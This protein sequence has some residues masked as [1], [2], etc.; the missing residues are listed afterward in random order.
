M[1]ID[2]LTQRLRVCV[3]ANWMQFSVIYFAVT[4][5][6]N[7]FTNVRTKW[8]IGLFSS[9]FYSK[10]VVSKLFCKRSIGKYIWLCW[11][12]G[13]CCNYQTVAEWKKKKVKENVNKCVRL[14]LNTTVFTKIASRQM[15]SKNLWFHNASSRKMVNFVTGSL[16][17]I[18]KKFFFDVDH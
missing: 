13:P 14:C 9:L 4:K 11:P 12:Y 5:V 18:S 6:Y 10:T 17:Q 15:W 3:Q 16:A 8:N 7:R 2:E 1:I